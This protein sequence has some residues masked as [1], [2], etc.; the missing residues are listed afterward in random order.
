[1]C[2]DDLSGKIDY[3]EVKRDKGR[4]SADLLERKVEAFL[5]KNPHKRKLARSVGLLSLED[6]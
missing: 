4:Y 5:E 1:M 6:M 3:F 2:E